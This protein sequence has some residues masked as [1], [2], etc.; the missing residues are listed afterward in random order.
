[1]VP[2]KRTIWLASI[3][4]TLILMAVIFEVSAQTAF[5]YRYVLWLDPTIYC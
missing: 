3:A 2:S 5:D 4:L 1:M